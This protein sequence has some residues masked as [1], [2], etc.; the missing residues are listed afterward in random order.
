MVAPLVLSIIVMLLMQKHPGLVIWL[1][2]T[3]C[4]LTMLADTL[5]SFVKAGKIGSI[6]FGTEL[7]SEMPE[8]DPSPLLSPFPTSD[9][10]ES[11]HCTFK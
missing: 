8:G 6:T 7:S 4:V 5:L 3:L 9:R 2:I 1:G 10:V 11:A